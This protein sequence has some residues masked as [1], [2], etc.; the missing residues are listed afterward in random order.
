M[1]VLLKFYR[2]KLN[3]MLYLLHIKLLARNYTSN[4]KLGSDSNERKAT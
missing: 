2:L 4:N 1:L 3:I